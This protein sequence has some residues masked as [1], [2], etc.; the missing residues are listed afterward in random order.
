MID[1]TT[2]FE[3]ET[4][5]VK[6]PVKEIPVVQDQGFFQHAT[7]DTYDGFFEAKKKDRS[8]KMHGPGIYTTA[9]GDIYNGVW[10]GDKLGANDGTLISFSDGSK[11]EGS[12]RDWCYNGS[13]KYLYP[14]GS[15]LTCSFIENSP[16][17]CLSL[18][19][20][21]GHTWLG[22]AD[23]GYAWLEPVNHFYE[24]LETTRDIGRIRRRHKNKD[25]QDQNRSQL[26]ANKK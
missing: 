13:G 21:N 14:D 2:D 19:D 18:T 7:G 15:L 25:V 10:D 17:G 16:F 24:L 1:T 6:K 3:S 20:P 5:E 22:N 23:Q 26:S 8:V 11:Y 4:T 12:F 9:E